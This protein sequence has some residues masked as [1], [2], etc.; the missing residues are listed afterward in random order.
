MPNNFSSNKPPFQNSKTD[1]SWAFTEFRRVGH[2]TFKICGDNP[3]FL[4]LCDAIYPNAQWTG[5]NGTTPIYRLVNEPKGYVAAYSPRSLLKRSRSIGGLLTPFEWWITYDIL[6]SNPRNLHLH[7]GGFRVGNAAVLLPGGHGA[8]K[9]SLTLQ[10]LYRGY[11][12]YSDEILLVDPERLILQ[13]YARCFVVKEPGLHLFPALQRIHAARSGRKHGRSVTVYYVNPGKVMED[14]LAS[15]APCHWLIF[16]RFRAGSKACL[17]PLNE[18]EVVGRLL[19][20]VFTFFLNRDAT[21]TGVA[22][23]ARQCQAFDFEFGDLHDGFDAIESL[24]AARRAA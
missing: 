1:H 3:A 17:R 23:L 12:V 2:Y 21:L 15:P 16:P 24:L 19:A 10:A 7:G 20:C 11:Q 14:Y 4:P 8:G 13:P 18:L 22:A 5:G 9:T 6:Y